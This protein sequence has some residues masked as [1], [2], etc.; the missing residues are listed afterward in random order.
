MS[1]QTTELNSEKKTRRAKEVR[2]P[3]ASW[4]SQSTCRASVEKVLSLNLLSDQNKIVRAHNAVGDLGNFSHLLGTGNAF[5]I[6]PF[7]RAGRGDAS[8]DC[9][10]FLRRELVIRHVLSELHSGNLPIMG[11]IDNPKMG[12]DNT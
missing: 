5:A 10:K 3:G 9:G 11:K 8:D 6:H 7:A 2:Q 4:R 12:R 1:L